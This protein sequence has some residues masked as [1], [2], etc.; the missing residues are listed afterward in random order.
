MEGLEKY[1]GKANHT[2]TDDMRRYAQSLYPKICDSTIEQNYLELDYAMNFDTNCRS[3]FGKQHCPNKTQALRVV[4]TG[5][6]P[7]GW[8]EWSFVACRHDA[9]WRYRAKRLREK[10]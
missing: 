3:C 8:I 5:L 2:I 4:N 9:G 7:D 1:Q 10:E 6:K